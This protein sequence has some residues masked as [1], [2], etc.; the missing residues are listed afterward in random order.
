LSQRRAD[1]VIR[2]LVENHSIPLRRIIT[3]YGY[4]KTNPVADNSTREGREKNRRVEVK[5]LVNKGLLQPAPTMNKPSVG[6]GDW[7]TAVPEDPGV[8]LVEATPENPVTYPV[9]HRRKA[10]KLALKDSLEFWPERAVGIWLRYDKANTASCQPKAGFTDIFLISVEAS[11]NQLAKKKKDF[12]THGNLT[13]SE[14]RVV[15]YARAQS[16]LESAESERLSQR[17]KATR[18]LAEDAS[19]NE[20]RRLL[21]EIESEELRERANSRELKR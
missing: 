2:Y 10:L 12:M 4:G 13:E 17:L 8:V 21:I 11:L 1:S 5:L 3:P 15:Y 9:S 14:M 20:Y 19:V 18:G 7:R 6:S 16:R